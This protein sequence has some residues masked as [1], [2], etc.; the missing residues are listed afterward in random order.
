[1]I[2]KNHRST[3]SLWLCVA[4]LA[5]AVACQSSGT[6][7]VTATN[8]AALTNKIDDDKDGK[9]DESD[10]GKDDDGDGKV[11]EAGEHS[12]ACK[13]RHD[14]ASRASVTPGVH[15][16][17]KHGDDRDEAKGQGGR[18]GDD[19]DL[20]C[21]DVDSA[22]AGSDDDDKSQKADRDEDDQDDEGKSS[23]VAPDAG[24]AP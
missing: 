9:V 24:A 13:K 2:A 6:T 15:G 5:A 1:M 21:S 14:G 17:G 3:V 18:S 22:D 19:S 8:A 7:P 4:A 11:D 12:D 23:A 20:D 16:S 10:E